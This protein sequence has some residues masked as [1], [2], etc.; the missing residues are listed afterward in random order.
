MYVDVCSRLSYPHPVKERFFQRVQAHGLTKRHGRT[1][2][3]VGVNLTLLP[4]ITLI[5][6]ANGSGKSTL[7]HLLALLTRP[8]R[9]HLSFDGL[10]DGEDDASLRPR[11]G[12]VAHDCMVYPDLSGSANLQ[13]T[14]RLHQVKQATARV[15]ELREWLGL[16]PWLDRPARSYSRGQRQRL[17]LAR[18]LLAAPDL[19]LLDEPSTGLDAASLESMCQCLERESQQAAI[20]VI[21]SHDLALSERFH[22]T[23]VVLDRGRVQ[24]VAPAS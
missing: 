12:L 14:S 16:G 2:A 9:G 17:S 3:L 6:G 15:D 20:V 1:F 8:T 13:L 22:C 4:G 19:L 23:H 21:V 18:A 24:E 7:L 10:R 5:R 11:I